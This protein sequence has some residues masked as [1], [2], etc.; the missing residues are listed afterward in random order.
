MVVFFL[1]LIWKPELTKIFEEVVVDNV[2]NVIKHFAQNI[3]KGEIVGMVYRDNYDNS[4]LDL[5]EKIKI[6]KTQNFKSK[7]I[8][9][10]L[11]ALYKINKNDVY[12]RVLEV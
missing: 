4:D 3:L 10:I 9:T 7:E 1:T 8:A 5:D 6:L 12:K 11:S 2:S